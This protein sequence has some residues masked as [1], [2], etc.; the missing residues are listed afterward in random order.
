MPEQ[1]P[2]TELLNYA[3]A[4][5]VAALLHALGIHVTY[6][7]APISNAVAMEILV[8]LL[9]IIYFLLVRMRLSADNPGA[10][11][12]IAEGTENFIKGQSHDIIGHGSDPFTPFLTT[13]F[14]FI[15]ICNLI[16]LIPG[17]EAPTA[18][19]AVP[20]GCAIFTF[21]F[22]HV[23]GL[24]K[25]GPWHYAK[26]FAGPM[27]ALAPLM[28]PIELISHAARLLS[29]TV[30]LYANMF[31]GD[32]VTLAFFS[33]VPIAIPVAFLALHIFVS[34]LQAYIFVLLAMVYIGGAVATEH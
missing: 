23:H 26:H 14:V 8:A 17:F 1:L 32:M 13:L 24:K 22:Y 21:V 29:L 27:P 16:G 11:Q 6:P 19:P 12:H 4:G 3:F 20:F 5:P 34:L 25:Q 2:F 31:A 7:E 9:L 33:L 10:L 28:V 18:V 15:L 30:R